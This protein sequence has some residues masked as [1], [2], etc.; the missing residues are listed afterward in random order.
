[1]QKPLSLSS[2][3][4]RPFMPRRLA[5]VVVSCVVVGVLAACGAKNDKASTQVAAK[6]NKDEISVHQVNFMLQRQGAVA[7]GREQQVSQEVV[8]R[9]IDQ[10]LALQQAEELKI[11]RDPQVLQAVDAA[12]RE[13]L[14]RAYL[15]RMSSSI[16][17]PTSQE[18]RQYY[19]AR[20]LLFA[21]RRIYDLREVNIEATPEQLQ[22][23]Q[24]KLAA[25]R[26]A[27]ELVAQ[28]RS[29]G[30]RHEVRQSSTAPETLPLAMVER[31]ASL[32]AGQ[33]LMLTAQGGAKVLFL[34]D[35]RP[36]PLDETTAAPRIERF[37]VNERKR[38]V[39]EQDLKALRAKAQIEYL[40]AFAQ[41]PSDAASAPTAN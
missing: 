28:L 18:I 11:D 39:F 22:R 32:G 12:R 24:P 8:E 13:I 4:S 38:Q 3:F 29:A 6:V 25:A 36:A 7:P 26:N 14:A 2:S 41:A 37:L 17:K 34:V 16:A 33:S 23:L 20:P 9:L 31:V 10:Q 1:M 21:Q 35:A 19:A 5:G 15:E 27:D 40:G 30:L